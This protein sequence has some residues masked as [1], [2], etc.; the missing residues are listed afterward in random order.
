MT[1]SRL[2]ALVALA[3]ALAATLGAPAAS[4]SQP[5]TNTT[6]E[7]GRDGCYVVSYVWNG[8]RWVFVRA[9]KTDC[10]KPDA[11]SGA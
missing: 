4:A 2:Q 8:S 9:Q 1:A 5:R 6:L 7:W 11:V 10:P 3:A